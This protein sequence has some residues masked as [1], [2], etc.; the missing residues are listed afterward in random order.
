MAKQPDNAK[1]AGRSVRYE[2]ETSLGRGIVVYEVGEVFIYI[3]AEL[4]AAGFELKIT[5][6]VRITDQV[7]SDD[8]FLFFGCGGD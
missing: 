6:R 8:F 1:E 2:V 5:G 3:P 7:L 4:S